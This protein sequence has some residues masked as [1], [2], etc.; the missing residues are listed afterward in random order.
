[1]NDVLENEHNNGSVE[2]ITIIL[3]I[4]RAD[5]VNQMPHAIR[6]FVHPKSLEKGE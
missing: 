1:M 6:D 4:G 2:C 3:F 5:T